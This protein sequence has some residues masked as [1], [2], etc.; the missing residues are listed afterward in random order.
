MIIA[1]G[2]SVRKKTRRDMGPFVEV[3]IVGIV[4]EIRKRTSTHCL[5]EKLYS[6]PEF[7]NFGVYRFLFLE[8]LIYSV[9]Q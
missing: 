8:L 7:D 1:R 5:C 2:G 4:P 6:I 3:C 9:N